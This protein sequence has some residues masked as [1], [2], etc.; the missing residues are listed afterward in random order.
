MVYLFPYICPASDTSGK[1]DPSPSVNGTVR[2]STILSRQLQFNTD[3]AQSLWLHNTN[4]YEQ[5]ESTVLSHNHPIFDALETQGTD[6]CQSWT[7]GEHIYLCLIWIKKKPFPL[8]SI[9]TVY[10]SEVDDS[11]AIYLGRTICF[12]PGESQSP[13]LALTH[14]NYHQILSHV[15][16][17]QNICFLVMLK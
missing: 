2:G 6:L 4:Q 11:Q 3:S 7:Y 1:I 10:F 16:I 9:D 13:S 17:T 12:S 14:E 5:E 8:L 15:N